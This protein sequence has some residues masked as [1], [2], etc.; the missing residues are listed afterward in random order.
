MR[1]PIAL[2]VALALSVFGVAAAGGSGAGAAPAP[3][4]NDPRYAKQWALP[5]ISAPEAWAT[6]TGAGVLIGEV[7]TGVDLAHQDLAGK[8][9][10]STNC[11]GSGGDPTQCH[12]DAQDDNGHGTHVAG[13]AAAVTGNATGVAGT[14]PGARLVVAKALDKNGSGSVADIDAGIEWVVDHGARVVNLSL[15]DPNFVYTSIFGSSLTQ[16]IEYAWS[17]GAIPVLASGNSDILGLGSSNY[18]NID[19]VVVG[20]VGHDGNLASYSSPTGNA[21]WAVLAPGGS[22]DGTPWDDVLSTYWVSGKSDQYAYLAGTS[23]AAPAVSGVLALL[24]STGLTPT[25]AVD[26][27]LGTADNPSACGAGAATCRGVI[28]AARAVAGLV[29]AGSGGG[30][31]SAPTPTTAPPA[32]STSPPTTPAGT[33]PRTG[34]SAPPTTVQAAPPAVMLPAHPSRPSAP[35]ARPSGSAGAQ[36]PPTTATVSGQELAGS[37]PGKGHSSSDSVVWFAVLAAVFAT[38]V[39]AGLV[40]V[41]RKVPDV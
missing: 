32:A 40:R 20:A 10:A 27:L 33:A 16:G 35:G 26:R 5:M 1:R 30:A 4:P 38:L 37:L 18:G 28:D 12:G 41:M 2:V 21:K 13:I 19:A 31:S 9:V 34:P 22:N 7:D 11:I 15:G 6:A 39:G 25:Q 23:M 24:L 29:A 3:A 8:V 36:A 14:A 17:R